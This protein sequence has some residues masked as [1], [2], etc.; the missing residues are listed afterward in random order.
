[1]L[2]W[3]NSQEEAAMTSAI[4]TSFASTLVVALTA[5]C[6]NPVLASHSCGHDGW[7]GHGS[8]KLTAK[9]MF[10]ANRST[11]V[12]D[13]YDRRGNWVLD[14]TNDGLITP[15]GIDVDD[16]NI[17]VVSQGANEVYAYLQNSESRSGPSRNPQLKLLVHDDTG[18]LQ[19]PFYTTIADGVLYV[20]SHDTNEVLRYDAETGAFI[21]V[22][23]T[24]G[25]DGLSGP[26]GLD[27]DS[28]GRLYV[29]SSLGNE[30]IV[31]NRR[32]RAIKHIAVGIP[33]PC[34]VSISKYDEICV[35]SAGGDGV[36]CYDPDGNEVYSDTAGKVC[37]LDFGPRG[38]LYTTRPDMN[39]GAGAVTVHS[40]R[41]GSQGEWFADTD[42]PAG[43]SWGE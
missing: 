10:V 20:S 40:L 26:R 42:L 43:L 11:N 36:H 4:R 18:R 17:Y 38:E 14:L 32:G 29:A 3:F 41:P 2:V 16:G 22:A 31:Y 23:V 34:G 35:G 39:G 8:D 33:T 1:M 13:A 7:S 24:S 15:F 9:R 12:V 37:G 6:A 5:L 30:V 25:E 27:F 21:D 19:K 28:K